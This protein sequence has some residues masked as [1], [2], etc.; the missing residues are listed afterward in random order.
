MSLSVSEEHGYFVRLDDLLTKIGKGKRVEEIECFFNNAIEKLIIADG[1]SEY[2]ALFSKRPNLSKNWIIDIEDYLREIPDE[3]NH[4]ICP[5]IVD[6]FINEFGFPIK[7][8]LG[9]GGWLDPCF[10]N[11]IWSRKIGYSLISE[12]NDIEVNRLY[13]VIEEET[14]FHKRLTLIGRIFDET[15]LSGINIEH[16]TLVQ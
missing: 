2:R 8:E 15:F 13:V 16:R 14:L 1:R 10:I 12:S 4:F 7:R 9:F 11:S 3:Y 6:F 5:E